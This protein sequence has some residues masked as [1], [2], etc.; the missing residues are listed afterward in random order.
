MRGRGVFLAGTVCAALA[1]GAAPALADHHEVR[2]VEVYPG[3]VTL[4]AVEYVQLEMVASGQNLFFGSG[5]SVTLIGTSGLVN[6]TVPLG[7][8]LT[9]GQRGRRI[10]V[11]SETLFTH[12]GVTPDFLFNDD[13]FLDPA[14]GAACFSAPAF[15]VGDCVSWGVFTGST[16]F[17]TG[18]ETPAITGDQALRRRRPACGPG[19]I[20]T[21]NPSNW[22]QVGPNPFNNAAPAATNAACPN[23]TITKKPAKKTTKRRARFKFTATQGVDDFKCKLDDRPFRDCTS[24]F[25]KRVSRGRHTFKVKADGDPLPASYSWKVKRPD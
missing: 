9:N 19:L 21:N 1:L 14:G 3:S 23:T 22:T 11:G 8:D 5:A 20:D 24:P 15:G 13:G 16:A 18:G 25:V 2:I 12:I 17:P 4:P 10:L 6:S 7:A